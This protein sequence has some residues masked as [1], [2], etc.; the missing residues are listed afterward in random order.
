MNNRL[1]HL[2][3]YVVGAVVAVLML[4]GCKPQV[5]SSYIQ[6]GEMEDILYDYY[7]AEAMANRTENVGYNQSLYYH[8]VLDKHGVSE[9]EF[10]SSLVYYYTHADRLAKIYSSLSDRMNGEATRLGASVN[11][12]GKYAGLS[13]NGDTANIW[14]ERSNAVLMPMAPYN[15]MDFVVKAD[16]TFHQGDSFQFNLMVNF[17]YQSGIKDGILYVVVDYDNDSTAVCLS[18]INGSGICDLTIPANPDAK[19]RQ[20]RGFIYLGQGGD[21]NTLQKL[22]FVN[23][24]QLIRFHHPQRPAEQDGQPADS[25]AVSDDRRHPATL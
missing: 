17:M 7:L 9:A 24:I 13:A 14:R 20:L 22:M 12:M 21:D 3:Q 16:T 10:D 1:H 25:A 6:P 18:R 5:P 15:R 4:V 23:D 2:H 19:V 11:E 8:A